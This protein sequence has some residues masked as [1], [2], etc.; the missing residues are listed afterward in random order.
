[1]NGDQRILNAQGICA[2][3]KS[4]TIRMSTPMSRI[5]S[6]MAI[7]TRPSGSPEENESSVTESVRQERKAARMVRELV[8]AGAWR[9]S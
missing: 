9:P 6:G 5:Q 4:P 1:M 2:R 7:Q 8:T 3:L